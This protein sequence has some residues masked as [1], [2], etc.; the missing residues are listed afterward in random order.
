M[1]QEH[2][3]KFSLLHSEEFKHRLVDGIITVDS[4]K[5]HFSLESLGACNLKDLEKVLK[6]T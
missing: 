4:D 3:R 6:S 5:Q 1:Y 2:G